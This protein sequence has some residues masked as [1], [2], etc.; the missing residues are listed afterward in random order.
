MPND[1]LYA[2]GFDP[3]NDVGAEVEKI[4]PTY[5]NVVIIPFIHIHDDASL[6][7]NNTAAGDPGPEWPGAIEKLKTGFPVA[8]RVLVSIGGWDNPNDWTVLGKDMSAVVGNLV[9]FAQ[10]NGI[11][12]FDL[13]FEG[14]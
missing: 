6:Y 11:D 4:G 1:I 12:G 9:D 14:G 13:D 7:L 2:Y 8:K 10:A 5:F 3:P